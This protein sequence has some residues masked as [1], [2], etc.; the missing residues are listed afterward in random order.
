MILDTNGLLF[1][2]MD[3]MVV[4]LRSVNVDISV[5]GYM[6]VDLS[7]YL[8]PG[9]EHKLIASR[10]HLCFA[11]LVKEDTERE[12]DLE[13]GIWYERA[14]GTYQCGTTVLFE[15]DHTMV[16]TPGAKVRIG[17][18]CIKLLKKK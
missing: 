18:N 5:G 4:S 3:N 6:G 10:C 2:D 17:P 13:T 14:R 1:G 16:V 11:P 15:P 7:G 8:L 12:R 9:K